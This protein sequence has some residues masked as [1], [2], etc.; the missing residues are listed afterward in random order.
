MNMGYNINRLNAKISGYRCD[1]LLHE[2]ESPDPFE[3]Y[4]VCEESNDTY[5]WKNDF[6][7][8]HVS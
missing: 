1:K 5:I 4:R 6:G 3:T 2:K 8:W 7:V